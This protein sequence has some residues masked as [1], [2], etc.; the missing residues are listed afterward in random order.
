M[1]CRTVLMRRIG[2][3]LA[4]RGCLRL[5]YRPCSSSS[6]W[7]KWEFNSFSLPTSDGASSIEEDLWLSLSNDEITKSIEVLSKLC[8]ATRLE[9]LKERIKMRSKSF[10]FAFEDPSNFNNVWASLR[11]IDSFGLQYADV[12]SRPIIPSASVSSTKV[13]KK[14]TMGPALGTQKWLSI[15]PHKSTA[16]C[17][18][19]ARDL[20]LKIVATDLHDS[21]SQS[22]FSVDWKA[23]QPCLLVFGNEVSGISEEMRASADSTFHIPMKGFAQSLNMAASCAGS[24][25]LATT[26][27]EI[28]P[29]SLCLLSHFLT[30]SFN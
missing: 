12:I 4:V 27:I 6:S 10:R 11:T 15:S 29:L 17:V 25:F 30:L 26:R 21:S 7:E 5:I 28:L 1:N 3:A 18:N 2:S 8:P 24:L 22:V 16:E 13:S 20:G 14:K 9:K 19:N 23:M